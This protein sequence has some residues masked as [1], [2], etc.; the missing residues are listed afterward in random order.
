MG[1]RVRPP[2]HAGRA[3]RA[4]GVTTSPPPGPPSPVQLAED[5]VRPVLAAVVAMA[6]AEGARLDL[7]DGGAVRW[8]CAVGAAPGDTGAPVSVPFLVDGVAVGSLSVVGSFDGPAR[9]RAAAGL[10]RV[11][12]ALSGAVVGGP[13]GRPAEA[14]P[15]PRGTAPQWPANPFDVAVL[16]SLPVGVI[17]VD[18]AGRVVRSNRQS[19]LWDGRVGVAADLSEDL[20]GRYQFFRPDGV[21]PFPLAELP[22]LRALASG[23]E[24]RA[25]LLMRPRGQ[26][27]VLVDCVSLPVRD[28]DGAVVGAVLSM[29]D[30]SERRAMEQQLRAAALNDGLTGLPNRRLLADRLDHAL[31][32]AR[33]GGGG[34]AVLYCDLDGFKAVNDVHGHEAGDEVLVEAAERLTRSVRPGDTVARV[35]GDEFVLVCPGVLDERDAQTIARRVTG[36]MAQPVRTTSGEHVVGISVGVA[37]GGARADARSLLQEADESMYRVKRS[38]RCPGPPPERGAGEPTGQSSGSSGLTTPAR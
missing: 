6:D 12:A 13:P 21:T 31:L 5:V 7:L 1:S 8:T 23:A 9:S 30:V 18:L 20:A 32:A 22:L 10:R 28:A 4:A 36:S 25:E 26:Q 35:G 33:R 24:A 3:R 16:E 11:A 37:L 19:Q 17:A 34:V 38:R 14:Q 29:V 15:A 27:A 2:P